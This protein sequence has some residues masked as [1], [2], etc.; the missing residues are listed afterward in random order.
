MTGWSSSPGIIAQWKSLRILVAF[1]DMFDIARS[2]QNLAQEAL[3]GELR[4]LLIDA[5]KLDVKLNAI[6]SRAKW[7]PY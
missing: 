1:S 2:L 3:N 4:Q 7:G 6:L 5:T